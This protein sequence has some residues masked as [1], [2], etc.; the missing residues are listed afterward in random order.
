MKRIAIAVP[1]LLLFIAGTSLACILLLRDTEQKAGVFI[2]AVEESALREDYTACLDTLDGFADFWEGRKSLYLLF[3]RHEEM[4]D[5]EIG[6]E[7]MTGFARCRDKAGI[8]GEL[9]MLKA[10]LKHIS[11]SELPVLINIL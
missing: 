11:D 5:I 3:V 8:V 10:R 2:D 1:L 7:Q 6:I 4:H 9:C